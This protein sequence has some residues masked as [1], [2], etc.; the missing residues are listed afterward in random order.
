MAPSTYYLCRL[1]E[2]WPKGADQG[3]G[4]WIYRPYITTKSGQ[5][6]WACHYGLKAF[7]IW[8]PNET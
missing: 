2:D 7:R 3:N 6:I 1:R 4:H 5:R 8:V